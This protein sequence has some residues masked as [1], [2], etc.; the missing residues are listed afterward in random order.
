[1]Y[2]NVQIA[3]ENKYL[4]VDKTKIQEGIY[5]NALLKKNLIMKIK[6]EEA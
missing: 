2:Y 3:I 1:M 6:W 5:T 4:R